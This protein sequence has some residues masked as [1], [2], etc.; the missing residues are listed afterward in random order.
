MDDKD[1]LITELQDK[2]HK[3]KEANEQLSLINKRQAQIIDAMTHGVNA[4]AAARN[5]A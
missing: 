4:A 3:A 2:L 1:T 5:L